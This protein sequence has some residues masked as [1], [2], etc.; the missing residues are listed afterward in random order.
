MRWGGKIGLSCD[1]H[2]DLPW[3]GEGLALGEQVTQ[4]EKVFVRGF[5]E[6]PLLLWQL[7]FGPQAWENHFPCV[8]EEAE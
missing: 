8:C 6:T 3:A 5:R 1:P 4:T 2:P 7:T